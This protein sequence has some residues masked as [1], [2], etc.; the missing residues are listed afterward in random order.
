MNVATDSPRRQQLT[1]IA[2][3]LFMQQGFDRTT[4]RML[5]DAMGIKSGSLFHHFADKQEILCAVI[6][7]S[8]RHALFSARRAL[9]DAAPTTRARLLALAR[10]HLDTLHDDRH[11]HGVALYEWRRLSDE[12]REHLTHLRDAYETLWLQVIEEARRAGQVQGDAAIITRYALG[13]LNWTARWYDPDGPM[14]T[15]QLAH[16]L[17]DMIVAPAS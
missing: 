2:A 3:R 9:A 8:T 5:A 17:V 12:D 11:A 15:A 6:E 10:V 7:D 13:A 4:V 16:E 1:R 14:D